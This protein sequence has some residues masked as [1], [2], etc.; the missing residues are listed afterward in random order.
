MSLRLTRNCFVLIGLATPLL[1]LLITEPALHFFH[2]GR[3]QSLENAFLE[4]V[5]YWT[6][7]FF[8][9]VLLLIFFSINYFKNWLIY[10]ASWYVPLSIVVVALT[11]PMRGS[12]LDLDRSVVAAWTMIALFGLTV[13]Y[14]IVRSIVLHHMTISQ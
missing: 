8:P 14:L 4:P 7:L 6:L 9:T 13:V 12:V 10:I 3:F 11:D 1:I 2:G 5:F